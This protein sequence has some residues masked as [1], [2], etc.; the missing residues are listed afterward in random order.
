MD[1]DEDE[2]GF[3]NLA[4]QDD[5]YEIEERPDSSEDSEQSGKKKKNG[6]KKKPS[7]DEK[8]VVYKFQR[9]VDRYRHSA[10]TCYK[11]QKYVSVLAISTTFR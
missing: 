3:D 11:Q 1:E 7:P 4:F 5:S 6:K 10:K 2:D 9:P 8:I